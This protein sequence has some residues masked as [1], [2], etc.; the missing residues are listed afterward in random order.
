MVGYGIW[1]QTHSPSSVDLGKV[2]PD[3]LP[4]DIVRTTEQRVI[5]IPSDHA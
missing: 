2:V 1:L 4:I 3:E 5:R